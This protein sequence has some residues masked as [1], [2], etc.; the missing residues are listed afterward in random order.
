MLAG[1]AGPEPG[2]Q[3]A[4]LGDET[5][6]PTL[7]A[8]A[9]VGS[10]PPEANDASPRFAVAFRMPDGTTRP[11]DREA[12]AFVPQWRSGAA[13]VDPERR[14]YEVLPDG[15]RRMLVA[16]ATG[17]LAVSPDRS[18]LAYVVASDVLGDLRVHDGS[19]E[20][21]L[22]SGLASIGNLRFSED[23]TL[24]AFVGASPGGIVGVWIAGQ[25]GARCLTNCALRTGEDWQDR[26]VPPPSDAD[27]F[28]L[29]VD[30][31]GWTDPDG[32]EH[33]IAIGGAP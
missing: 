24:V 22:A 7:V 12:I 21:T 26:F 33:E 18:E 17:A 19:T 5:D 14:L 23:G 32:A 13:L 20:R 8:L 3:R 10:Q 16:G 2:A 29:R 27:R 28:V 9:P 31:I 15:M 6:A 25:G 11:V 30:T 1:C 4:L